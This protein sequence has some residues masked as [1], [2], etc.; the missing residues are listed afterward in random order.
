MMV[1]FV[2]ASQFQLRLHFLFP[3]VIHIDATTDTNK[4]GCSLLT[5]KAKGTNSKFFVLLNC[6]LPN[7]KA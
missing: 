1:A 7:E 5:I 6:Y 2:Y 3:Q 4:E